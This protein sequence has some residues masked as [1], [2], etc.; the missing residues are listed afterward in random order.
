MATDHRAKHA[1]T[2]TGD[3]AA[4]ADKVFFSDSS[5]DVKEAAIGANKT[6]LA[7]VFG[8][9]TFRLPL[10]A[11]EEIQGFKI[12]FATA[13]TI[14]IVRGDAADAPFANFNLVT[15]SQ[16]TL[17]I[18]ISGAGGLQTGETEA[19][20]T[21][22][23]IMVIGDSFGVNSTDF[24]LIPAGQVFSETGFDK[25]RQIGWVRNNGSSDFIDFIATGTGKYRTVMWVNDQADRAVLVGGTATTPTAVDCSSLVPPN[26]QLAHLGLL[27]NGTPSV[28]LRLSAGGVAISQL[29]RAQSVAGIINV[30]SSQQIFYDNDNPAGN[31][32][33]S[34][35]GYVDEIG[36]ILN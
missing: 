7:S 25:G 11:R 24:L 34:V 27:Q 15:T 22:Y 17:D 8:V 36:N 13:S 30:S 21:W 12:A 14:T 28:F 29:N 32:D 31:V 10:L 33:I 2:S 26:S 6:I 35:R 4:G 20:D 19:A 16:K 3:H 5:G 1:M 18:T 9:P 23:R